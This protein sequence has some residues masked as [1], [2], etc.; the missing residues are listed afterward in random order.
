[1]KFGVVTIFPEFFKDTLETGILGRAARDGL[2]ETFVLDLRDFS[3]DKHRTVDDASFGGGAGMVLKPEPLAKAIRE[4]KKNLPAA[5]FFALTPGGRTLTDAMARELSALDSLALICGRYEGIDQRI[6]DHYCDGEI[7][8]GDYVL[9]GG[10]AA[11]LV[12]IDAVTRQI[13]GVVGKEENIETESFRS[14]LKHPVY[15]RPALFEGHAVP[16][17]L[18]NGN[19]EQILEWRNAAALERTRKHR[20]H[21]II[22]AARHRIMLEFEGFDAG[23]AATI[24]REFLGGNARAAI[25]ISNDAAQRKLFR[26]SLE[27][28]A[29]SAASMREA[30]KKITREIGEFERVFPGVDSPETRSLSQALRSG[31]GVVVHLD[32]TP[33]ENL[34]ERFL[35]LLLRAAFSD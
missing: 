20:P 6:I 3:E 30:G 22:E 4:M 17:V 32:G 10:E 15:T 13:P 24:A 29:Q 1:M 33:R 28:N 19:A 11:A 12:V 2:F 8:I 31:N 27:P 23:S 16:D 18:R 25:L 5:K 7:S 35:I 34:R 26:E 14:G 9:T 21:L